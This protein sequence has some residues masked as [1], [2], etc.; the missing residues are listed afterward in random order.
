MTPQ[1]SKFPPGGTL[2]GHPL[3]TSASRKAIGGFSSFLAKGPRF[4]DNSDDE[5]S[6]SD[7]DYLH[8]L[9]TG[10][11][12]SALSTTSSPRDSGTPNPV[13]SGSAYRLGEEND[14][15][16]AL[17]RKLSA[18]MPQKKLLSKQNQ[19]QLGTEQLG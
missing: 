17:F 11:G 3:P 10:G 6:D 1:C 4:A 9:L 15:Y 5:E 8:P 12:K 7:G 16:S 13:A 2:R 14:V 19:A 18:M